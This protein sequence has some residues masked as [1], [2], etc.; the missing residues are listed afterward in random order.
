MIACDLGSNTFRVVKLNCSTF[1]RIKEYEKI[2]KTA[3]NLYT[4]KIINQNALKRVIEA[5]KEAKKEFD[6]ENDKVS[7]VATAALRMAE[8][9]EEVLKSIE[10]ETGVLFKIIDGKEEARLTAVAVRER[11]KKL[12]MPYKHFINIDLGGGSTEII[13]NKNEQIFA[14]SIDTGIVTF[15]QRYKTLKM[16][17]EK[18]FN[19]YEELKDIYKKESKPPILTAT[20]GTPTTIAAFLKN[21]NYSNYDY[22]KINGT[23]ISIDEIDKALEKLL[24]LN[25]KDREK[26]V[27]TGRG[28]LIIAGVFL[29]KR[30][31]KISGFKSIVVIDDSLREGVAIEGCKSVNLN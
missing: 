21:M 19:A 23:K 15:A 17:K 14:K 24:C 11:L 12:N 2:V 31:I 25:I 4:T 7:A 10:K 3:D 28:D 13:I 9:K 22:K 30:V 5:I 8:N 26:W 1:E 29:L 6:F 18:S 16:I 20:A 27:G